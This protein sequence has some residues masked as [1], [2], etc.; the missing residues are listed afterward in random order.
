MKADVCK[1]KA[2]L[3]KDPIIGMSVEKCEHFKDKSKFIELPCKVGD[4]VYSIKHNKVNEYHVTSIQICTR[5][6]IVIR[7]VNNCFTFHDVFRKDFGKTV[8]LT[9]EEAEKALVKPNV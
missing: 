7:L 5:V 4:T 3:D 8:F 1:H 9:K 2:N 6:S